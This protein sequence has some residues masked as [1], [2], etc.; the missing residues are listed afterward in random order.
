[1]KCDAS[2]WKSLIE[3]FLSHRLAVL[4]AVI[5]VVEILITVFLPII[6]DLDPYTSQ[7]GAFGAIPSAEHILGTDD[8]GRDLFARL[9]YGGRVSLFV[10]LCSTCISIII[11]VPLGLL[12][13]FYR[14]MLETIIMRAADI[15]MSFPAIMLIL[16]LVSLVGPS[17]VSVMV[18]IGILG[19]TQFARLVYSNVISVREQEYIEAARSS[20]TK[21]RTIIFKYILP[22]TLT[23]VLISFTFRTAQAIIME[24]SLSFL[25]M[26]VRPPEASWGNLMYDAQSIVVLSQKPWVWLPPGLALVLT[27]LSINFLGD[28]IR[29]ALDP[30]MKV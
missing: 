5:L 7:L 16:V 29:D 21:N 13:G 12:A 17:I 10:G 22:N 30:K 20:G 14:G 4:G 26:G 8:I 23:P 3:K 6:M 25:G 19:W 24:S 11:G 2:K 27:V 15:F 18:V 1:M 9:I 28:G